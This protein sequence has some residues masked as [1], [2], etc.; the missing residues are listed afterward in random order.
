MDF[1]T[2]SGN[3]RQHFPTASGLNVIISES[4]LSKVESSNIVPITLI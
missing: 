1:P 2:E 4:S 3:Y